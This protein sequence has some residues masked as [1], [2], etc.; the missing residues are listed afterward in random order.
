MFNL[1]PELASAV[2]RGAIRSAAQQGWRKRL[3]GWHW[4][5]AL[6]L[7]L[8][9]VACPVH[10]LTGFR[11]GATLLAPALCAP[12]C[13]V[14]SALLFIIYFHTLERQRISR[15]IFAGTFS[16]WPQQ[17]GLGRSR[18]LGSIQFSRV[19]LSPKLQDALAG[20]RVRSRGLRLRSAWLRWTEY[21]FWNVL[22]PLD[23]GLVI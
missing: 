4:W 11:R 18:S 10:R 13:G 21:V 19:H 22:F 6:L 8:T 16:K 14:S 5:H 12:G 7:T 2:P 23:C 1:Q 20:S 9:Q 17:P 15:Q 3:T